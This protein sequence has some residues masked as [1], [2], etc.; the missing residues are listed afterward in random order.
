MYSLIFH[1]PT[2][3]FAGTKISGQAAVH[4]GVCEVCSRLKPDLRHDAVMLRSQ[5]AL[6]TLGVRAFTNV[7]RQAGQSALCLISLELS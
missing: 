3:A 1:T 6:Q 2:F 7:T 5:S 4:C